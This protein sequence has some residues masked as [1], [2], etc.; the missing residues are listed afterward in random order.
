M[1]TLEL[2]EIASE[3]MSNLIQK[4]KKILVLTGLTT[5]AAL[6]DRIGVSKAAHIIIL[7]K[8]DMRIKQMIVIHQY[9]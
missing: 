6:L 7:R 4:N 9:L 3:K 8:S 1:V 5:S 2:L